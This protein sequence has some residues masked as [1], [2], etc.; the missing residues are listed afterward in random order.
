PYTLKPLLAKEM[1]LITDNGLSY[2][3]KLKEDV[4]YHP[5]QALS[6]KRKV[7]AQDFINQMKR[8]A[9]L[10]TQSNGWWIFSGKIKGL[11]EFRKAAKDLKDFENLKVEGLAALDDHTLQIKLTAPYPQL[12]YALAMS[13]AAPAP[14]ELIKFYDNDFSQEPVGTGPFIFKK[15][16]KNLSLAL[17]ANPNYHQQ[18]YPKTGDRFAYEN[19]LLKDAGKKLPFVKGVKFHIMKEAGPRM[20]NF[21]SRNIDLVTLTK[22]YFQMALNHQGELSKEFKSQ[23]IQL[24][25]AP[26]LTYWW[27]SFN[28]RDKILGKNLK[29][30][31]AIAHAVDN[32]KLI[33]LF[34]NNIGQK[35][36]S[37]YPP[38]IPGYDP[39][40]ELP[41][42]HNSAKA[43]ALL[44]AAGYPEGKG[45]P[46]FNYD[47]RGSGAVSRQMGEFIKSEL[48]K[49]GIEINVVINT[50]PGFLNKA[51]TGQLQFWQGGWAMDY[52]DAEN[53]IQLLTTQN[54][55]PGPNTAYYSNP[56]VDALYGKI[57]SAK[58]TEDQYSI[59]QKVE[60][61]VNQELPWIMQYYSRN[62]V[63]Y[64]QYVKNFRQSDLLYNTFKYI[65]L[66]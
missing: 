46:V 5:H 8:L 2:L 29:L 7:K 20:Q 51:R 43:K 34:T 28:M 26:T 22:D 39:S 23:K 40:A 33:K 47:V 53:I 21:L 25:I 66:D 10:P 27:L 62:Y 57:M 30:R 3:I 15:W 50:F 11:D 65:R 52:P 61:E 44:K 64:H 63:L 42:E 55:P 4:Y 60:K 14:M 17:E 59:M 32:Q 41:Y 37:I 19:K 56:K 45:L 12:L 18:T 58:K 38:G 54:H 35:A 16:E 6:S 31:Q 9:Y 1:P 24:Q 36:N 48:Q 13:F 49:I